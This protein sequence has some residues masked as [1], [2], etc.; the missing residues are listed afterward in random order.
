MEIRRKELFGDETYEGY[1]AGINRFLGR[2]ISPG[3]ANGEDLDLLGLIKPDAL[4]E[5]LFGSTFMRA[6]MLFLSILSYIR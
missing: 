1:S 5:L 2:A 3:S 6:L 4:F